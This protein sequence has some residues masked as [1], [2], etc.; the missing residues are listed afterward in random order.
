MEKYGTA[1]TYYIDRGRLGQY[2]V[3]AVPYFSILNEGTVHTCY[4]T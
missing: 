4:I 1:K 2:N 3:L